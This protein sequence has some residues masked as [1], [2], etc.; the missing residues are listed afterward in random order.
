M[1]YMTKEQKERVREMR[2][3][4]KGYATIARELGL[5]KSQVS[6][7]CRRQGLTGVAGAAREP[8]DTCPNCGKR[9]IR[10]PGRKRARFCCD[11]CRHAW[12]N[13]HPELIR[14]K[15]YYEFDCACCGKRFTAYGNDHR[16]YCSHACYIRARFGGGESHG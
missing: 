12:W 7:F 16:K 13:S 8:S 3:A 10:K 6:S 4:G 1:V 14:R 9:L 15:A 5:T 11:A 2:R